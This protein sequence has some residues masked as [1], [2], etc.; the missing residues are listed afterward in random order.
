MDSYV[1]VLFVEVCKCFTNMADL[2]KCGFKRELFDDSEKVD[3]KDC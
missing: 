3:S 1:L 2:V